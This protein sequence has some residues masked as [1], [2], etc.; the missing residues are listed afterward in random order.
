M[1]QFR[2]SA[3]ELPRSA[4]EDARVQA[5]RASLRSRGG[6][7]ELKWF[8]PDPVGGRR[9]RSALGRI[10]RLVPIALAE[11]SQCRNMEMD[12]LPFAKFLDQQQ[13]I[14]EGGPEL[15]KEVPARLR[16]GH[17]Q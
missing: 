1:A 4:P 17:V 2:N 3:H 10:G 12:F 6:C 8:N 9:L 7:G 11:P 14:S 13:I 16:I 5:E 15:V